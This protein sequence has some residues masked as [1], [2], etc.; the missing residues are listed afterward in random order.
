MNKVLFVILMNL[1]NMVVMI[2]ISLYPN[3]LMKYSIEIELARSHMVKL[4]DQYGFMHPEVQRCSSQLDVLLLKFYQLDK[5][6]KLK[7][8]EEYPH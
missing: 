4:V 8:L 5:Q 3:E 1:C 2:L 6:L 7:A